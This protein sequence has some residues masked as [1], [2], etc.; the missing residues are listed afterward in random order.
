MENAKVGHL[1]SV[2]LLP[3][4]KTMAPGDL[5][6]LV[7]SEVENTL[8]AADGNQRKAINLGLRRMHDSGL[9][10]N[11][12]VRNLEKASLIVFSVQ[13]GHQSAEE[14]AGELDALHRDAVANPESST[15]GT[16]MVGGTY[17]ARSKKVSSGM[18]LFGMLVGALLTGGP[19]GMLVG[20]LVG[21]TAGEVCGDDDD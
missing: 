16:T 12:D 5:F 10:T 19:G 17:S 18:G 3:D 11:T 1:S 7:H 13:T 20:G 21:W 15:M 2:E 14:G 9:I 8:R 4:Y 6:D